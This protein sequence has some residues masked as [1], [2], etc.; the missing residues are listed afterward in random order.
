MH[1]LFPALALAL[2]AMPAAAQERHSK[3]GAEVFA[4]PGDII[5]AEGAFAQ[6]RADKGPRAAIRATAQ[7]DALT[8]VPQPVRVAD[9]LK[10]RTEPSLPPTWQ[11]Q[12]VWMSCDGSYAV[13]HGAWQQAPG[14]GWYVTIWHRQKGGEYKWVLDRG[15]TTDAAPPTPD[16]I[17]ASVADCPPRSPHGK[18]PGPASDRGKS[19][20]DYASYHSDDGTLDWA[21]MVAPAGGGAFTLREKQDGA[22]RDVLTAP[23]APDR[24]RPGG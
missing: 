15:G 4:E 13:T 6:L 23:A 20:P 1:R 19:L 12:Q 10:R 17:A 21:T 2:A 22:W 24:N 14:Q 8:Y 5:A 18:P 3:G 9:Y 16:M 7:S 11:P